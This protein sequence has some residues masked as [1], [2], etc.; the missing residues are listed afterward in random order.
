MP[1][2][3][4]LLLLSLPL[5]TPAHLP[6]AVVNDWVTIDASGTPHTLAPSVT[7]ENG[8]VRTLSG[9]PYLLTG[10]VFTI[11]SDSTVSTST[12]S[13][14]PPQATATSGAG[15]Q[16]AVCHNR[17]GK[18][19]PF[20]EPKAGSDLSLGR[21]YYGRSFS[22]S[23]LFVLALWA[24]RIRMDGTD[25]MQSPGTTPSSERTPATSSSTSRLTIS[26][27]AAAS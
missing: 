2:S 6:R 7:T 10:S 19:G 26:P 18:D 21:T 25:K 17:V 15:G 27:P 3:R 22:L 14:P 8:A 24:E 20:C 16:F 11:S 1:F 23:P 9:A 5:A 12:G 13:P 4:W